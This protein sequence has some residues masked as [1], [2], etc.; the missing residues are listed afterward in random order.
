M[1][2][3]GS[4][5][6]GKVKFELEGEPEASV[7]CYCSDCR[8]FSGNLGHIV[9]QYRSKNFKVEDPENALTEYV[10]KKTESGKPK[11]VYFCSTCGC[12]TH[13]V[14]TAANGEIAYVRQTLVD[15][16]FSGLLPTSSIF[17]A[18]KEKVTAGKKS[19]YY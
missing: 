4:C 13:T 1:T 5:D 15:G 11:L 9:A 2:Y 12:T 10:A 8:K 16:D 18:E 6:C 3:S 14:P 17:D 19:E 7:V